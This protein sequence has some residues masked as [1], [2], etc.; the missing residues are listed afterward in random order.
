MK[1]YEEKMGEIKDP[2]FYW[3]FATVNA[4]CI[5]TGYTENDEIYV[6]C[7][8]FDSVSG[9]PGA[10]DDGSGVAAF[11]AC[12]YLMSQYEFNHTIRFVGFSGEEQGL[13]RAGGPRGIA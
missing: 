1:D 2:L 12:A 10:D 4:L 5:L 11:L 3:V 7:A 6:V 8:H 9:A 13:R